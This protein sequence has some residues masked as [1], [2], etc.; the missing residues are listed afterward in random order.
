MPLNLAFASP[1][2]FDKDLLVFTR[3]FMVILT[4][5]LSVSTAHTVHAQEKIGVLAVS[6]GTVKIINEEG[7]RRG[8]KGDLIYRND[9]ITTGGKSRAQVLLLDQTAINIS[10]KAELTLNAFVYGGE[11]DNIGVKVT[12]GTF[13]FISGKIATNKPENVNVETPVATIGVRGT[14]FLGGVNLDNSVVA[15]LN[16]KISVANDLSEELVEI[17]GYG[18]NI[19]PTG[20]ISPP[21]RLP[22]AELDKLLNAV[23]TRKE[24]LDEEDS[25]EEESNEDESD[26]EESDEEESDEEESN[27]DESDEE[28]SD[29]EESDEE[30]S[31]EE[32]SDEEGSEE[33]SDEEGSEEG[34]DE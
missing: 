34:S 7:V 31:D 22:T 13:R 2:K 23:S 8:K 20:N 25:D 33:G 26:E 14:E 32:G 1:D 16:G 15:L 21:S 19:D 5:L 29:E 18:V 28:G 6:I 30:E 12:K 3:I 10:Q 4:F 17:P 11:N 24:T 9:V 27:E